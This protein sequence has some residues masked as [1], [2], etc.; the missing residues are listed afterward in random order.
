MFGNFSQKTLFIVIGLVA[1][2]LVG[3]IL[4]QVHWLKSAIEINEQEFNDKV[5]VAIHKVQN[6][7]GE[8]LNFVLNNSSA[9]KTVAEIKLL[10]ANEFVLCNL[11]TEFELA[12]TGQ[13]SN[14]K[15]GL[16]EILSSEGNDSGITMP[17]MCSYSM[18][19]YFPGKDR[20]L[21]S[22]LTSTLAPSI[23]FILLLISCFAYITITLSKQKRIS[24]IKNDFINNLTHEFQ[25]PLS[26]ISLT[27]RVIQQRI[28]ER[29]DEKDRQYFAIIENESLRLKGQIDKVLQMAQIDSGVFALDKTEIN[30]HDIIQ[31]VIQNFDTT[32]KETNGKILLKFNAERSVMS[33][34]ESHL[35]NM[36][37]NLVDNACKYSAK[38]PEITIT[39][40]NVKEGLCISV[41]DNGIGIREEVQK[42]IFEKF[43]RV[44][45][46]NIHNAKGFG[47]GL[48]YVK[49]IVN[50]HK[51]KIS[52]RSSINNGSEF[53][54]ILPSV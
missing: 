13:N 17:F 3:L 32:I 35:T 1:F 41:K 6:E 38:N 40:A 52:I 49:S 34:D 33:G 18:N 11:P 30:V 16:G 48:S 5:C 9:E 26:S 42:Y 47:L 31:R 50:A 39:T 10:L 53:Q 14:S 43:Y 29:F 21:L 36:I 22:K 4:I 8:N 20:I 46:G 54:I 7:Y 2:S 51:G 19:I 37:Y 25:T 45:T 44:P 28:P 27:N 23:V 12:L 24:E 15:I